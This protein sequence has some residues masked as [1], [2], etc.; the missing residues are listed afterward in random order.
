[1]ASGDGDGELGE[2]ASSLDHVHRQTHITYVSEYTKLRAHTLTHT[3]SHTHFADAR[4]SRGTSTRTSAVSLNIYSAT[5]S[6]VDREH[7]HL[8][9]RGAPLRRAIVK[10]DRADVRRSYVDH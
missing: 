7:F 8:T 10:C 3:P 2:R 4:D 5:C 9:A 1:M 6:D